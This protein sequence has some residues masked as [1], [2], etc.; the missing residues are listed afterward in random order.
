M[1]GYLSKRN[2]GRR[3]ACLIIHVA[4]MMFVLSAGDIH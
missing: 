2:D 3:L 4:V 1:P